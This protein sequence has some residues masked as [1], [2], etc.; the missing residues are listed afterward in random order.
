MLNN[1]TKSRY[2]SGP[3]VGTTTPA[4]PAFVERVVYGRFQNHG[5]PPIGAAVLALAY[6]GLGDTERAIRF[7]AKLLPL[8]HPNPGSSS[9]RSQDSIACG[10]TLASES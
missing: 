8:A 2:F 5:L 7:L 3:G 1:K 6:A 4:G 9:A 10:P